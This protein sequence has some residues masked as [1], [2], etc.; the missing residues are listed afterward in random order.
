MALDHYDAIGRWRDAILRP[1]GKK[2]VKGNPLF[3]TLP[4]VA[5]DTLPGGVTLDGLDSLKAYLLHERKGQFARAFVTK[6]L[7]YALGR[8]ITW[9]DEN[10]VEELTRRFA[11]NGYKLPALIADIVTSEPFLKP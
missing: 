2:G 6:L 1:N 3:D 7:A 5:K 11:A 10:A 9:T 4:V 8:G